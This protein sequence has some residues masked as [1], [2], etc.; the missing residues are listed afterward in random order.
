[1]GT[2]TEQSNIHDIDNLRTYKL[3]K[4]NFGCEEYIFFFNLIECLVWYFQD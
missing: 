2:L 1:M 3:L 4:L